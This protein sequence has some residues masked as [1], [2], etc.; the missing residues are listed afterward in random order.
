MPILRAHVPWI[1]VQTRTGII[2]EKKLRHHTVHHTKMLQKKCNTLGKYFPNI[3]K[4]PI[5]G[6]ICDHF[7]F[8]IIFDPY[9]LLCHVIDTFPLIVT[10]FLDFFFT[11]IAFP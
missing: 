3:L 9:Q 8:G 2:M 11:K 7:I 10:L 5:F 6:L 1:Q 4:C